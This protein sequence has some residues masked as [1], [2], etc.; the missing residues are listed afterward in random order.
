MSVRAQITTRRVA[1]AVV[2]PGLFAGMLM[3][4]APASAADGA[5]T[6]ICN[7]VTNQ[8]AH[9]GN[10]QPNL[11]KAAA[12]QNAEQIAKLQAERA[13]LVIAQNAL[14]A[15]IVAAEKEIAALDAAN[16]TLVG[17]IDTREDVADQARGGQ[18]HAR[19]PRTARRTPSWPRSRDEKTALVNQMTPLKTQLT[20]A[21]S[22]LAGLKTKKAGVA[23][24]LATKRG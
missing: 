11:L 21:Q 3:F 24:S 1:S 23:S 12:K 17:Q 10:A 19:P 14:T 7:G 9:R 16:A 18:G 22:E 15:Q 4:A 8:L 2:L 20:D 13:A 5:V 6:G